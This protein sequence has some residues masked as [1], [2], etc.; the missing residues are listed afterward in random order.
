MKS[1]VVWIDRVEVAD[2]VIFALLRSWQLRLSVGP[3][4]VRPTRSQNSTTMTPHDSYR[5]QNRLKR[6]KAASCE[7]WVAG[8]IWTAVK[9]TL[10][11][12]IQAGDILSPDGSSRS[13]TLEKNLRFCKLIVTISSLWMKLCS[14][15]LL[16]SKSKSEKTCWK[17]CKLIIIITIVNPYKKFLT[18]AFICF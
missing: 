15:E 1:Y 13:S 16:K 12:C 14:S 4:V 6:R 3:G 8:A 10:N 18:L 9:I 2:R 17:F 5:T 11:R 7:Q